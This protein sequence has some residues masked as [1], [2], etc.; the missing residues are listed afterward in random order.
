MQ[1]QS[2]SATE[3]RTLG[4]YSDDVRSVQPILAPRGWS[5][6]AEVGA[7]G[8]TGIDIYPPGTSAGGAQE[9]SAQSNAECQGCTYNLVCGFVPAAAQQLG[10]SDEP[11]TGMRPTAESVHFEQGS[12][13]DPGDHVSDVIEFQDP[14]SVKAPNPVNGVLLYA[15]TKGGDGGNS[16]DEVCVLPASEHGVCTAVLNNFIAT[17]WLMPGRTS[18]SRS[19]AWSAVT[20]TCSRSTKP[21]SAS[22]ST[23]RNA[24]AMGLTS[25][26]PS[27]FTCGGEPATATQ[28][29][30]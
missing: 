8:T 16:S 9:V 24:R 5:C 17:D 14:P 27:S 7:D 15:W 23:P 11:C 21:P 10:Y 26:S 19:S 12:A 1:V 20:S 6:N 18:Y 3:A 22:S 13:S 29:Q 4:Y 28:L 30:S 25:W 2:V